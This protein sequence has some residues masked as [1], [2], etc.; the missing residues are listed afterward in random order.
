MQDIELEHR[1]CLSI[2]DPVS[3]AVW[4]LTSN[5]VLKGC[6][7]EIQCETNAKMTQQHVWY[8]T[9]PKDCIHVLLELRII[10]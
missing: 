7:E 3:L 4:L 10:Y 2:L 5:F 1:G 8:K 6:K 9:S